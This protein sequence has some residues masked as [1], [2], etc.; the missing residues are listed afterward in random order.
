MAASEAES[1]NAIAQASKDASSVDEGTAAPMARP[2]PAA[3]GRARARPMRPRIDLDEQISQANKLAEVSKKLLS[4]AKTAQKNQKKQKQ[5]LIRKAGKLSA[6]DLERIAVLKRCGLYADDE[7]GDAEPRRGEKATVDRDEAPVAGP[8]DKKQKLSD[9]CQKIAGADIVL[10]ALGRGAASSGSGA[11]K[12][13][14]CASNSVASQEGPSGGRPRGL[15][16]L[17]ALSKTPKQR[18]TDTTELTNEV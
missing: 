15:R 1:T 3:K 17:R 18:T 11:G 12:T 2:P 6:Q 13:S 5:R 16:L 8:S 7:D 14:S 4:A 9:V 10:E